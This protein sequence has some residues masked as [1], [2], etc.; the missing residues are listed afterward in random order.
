MGE[1]VPFCSL[2]RKTEFQCSPELSLMP[3]VFCP[4]DKLL[5]KLHWTVL[6]RSSSLSES[7]PVC[8]DTGMMLNVSVGFKTNQIFSSQPQPQPSPTARQSQP[9]ETAAAKTSQPSGVRMGTELSAGTA[10]SPATSTSAA[11]TPV[12]ARLTGCIPCTRLR[13]PENTITHC[14]NVHAMPAN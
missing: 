14:T 7:L 4:E 13:A 12:L 9:Q 2:S 1:T 11:H 8:S 10:P 3:Q 5:C 6:V